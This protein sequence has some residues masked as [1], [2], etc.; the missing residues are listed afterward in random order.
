MPRMVEHQRHHRLLVSVPFNAGR[1][2][3]PA[4]GAAG[5]VAGQVSVPFNAGRGLMQ[6]PIRAAVPGQLVSVPFNA[7]RGLMHGAQSRVFR[8]GR[9][10]STLQCG[11]WIDAA[12]AL[13]IAV[14]SGK[15]FSTLQCGS[16][17][18]AVAGTCD[19]DAGAVVSVP[20]NAG[21][22]LMHCGA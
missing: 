12:L 19:A 5:S 22:G 4:D 9:G 1:G 3:M 13:A 15:S 16:W 21:R 6:R 11:S 8:P 17:I 14:A 7:G 2:L 18:D 20:F 10:F